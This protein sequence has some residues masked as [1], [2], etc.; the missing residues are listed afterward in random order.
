MFSHEYK[1]LSLI[2]INEH[3][4]PSQH[5][6]ISVK[7]LMALKPQIFSSVNLFPSTVLSFF[8]NQDTLLGPYVFASV[9]KT[10]PNIQKPFYISPI[11]L[12]S[13]LSHNRS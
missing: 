5:E 9:H 6:I 2:I 4:W 8:D 1:C 13:V 11:V 3:L 7:T 12:S 10:L